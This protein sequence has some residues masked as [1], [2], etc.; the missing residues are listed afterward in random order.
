MAKAK[1]AEQTATVVYVG[2]SIPGVANQFTFYREGIPTALAEA[3]R[4]TPAMEGLVIPLEQ[5]P[6]AMKMLRG[7]SGQIFRLYRLVQA[8]H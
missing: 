7:G 3:I 5:L 4:G 2:P 8:N 1:K 6:E